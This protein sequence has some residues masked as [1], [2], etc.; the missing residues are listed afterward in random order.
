M[1]L[2]IYV[3]QAIDMTGEGVPDNQ[4]KELLDAPEGT[5]AMQILPNDEALPIVTKIITE[6]EYRALV[7]NGAEEI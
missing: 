2:L 5:L 7:D 1:A 4:V 3:G 6:E